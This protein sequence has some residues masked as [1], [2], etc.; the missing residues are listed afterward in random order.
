M[1]TQGIVL[2]QN[3]YEI[4]VSATEAHHQAA[5]LNTDFAND[6]IKAVQTQ[7][8]FGARHIYRRPFDVLPIPTY[9]AEDARHRRL[10]S[11]SMSLMNG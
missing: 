4:W 5:L 8:A 11:L 6:A 9:R 3:F 10:A 1:Q 7:G 2:D